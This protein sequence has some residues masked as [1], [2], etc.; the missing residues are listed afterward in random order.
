MSLKH[1]LQQRDWWLRLELGTYAAVVAIVLAIYL[2][3][4]ALG[5]K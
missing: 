1:K 3:S 5:P 2:V 4:V